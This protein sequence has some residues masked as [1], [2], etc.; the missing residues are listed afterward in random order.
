MQK[1]R[2]SHYWQDREAR[3]EKAK[4]HVA[5]M[6][7]RFPSSI[8]ASIQGTREYW[9]SHRFMCGAGDADVE[10][11]VVALD[12]VSAAFEYTHG[13][14][15]VLNF[16][17]YK[18]PGGAFLAGSRAQEECLC[19][20]S[21]LYHVLSYFQGYY[22]WNKKNLNR[23]LY[24]DRAL[25]SPNVVFVHED[26]KGVVQQRMIDVLTCAAPNFS[27]AS[28]HCSKEENSQ[29]LK[30]RIRFV[31]S[32]MAENNVDTA[33]LGAFGCGVFAQDAAE[34]AEL[35]KEAIPDVFAGR[36]VCIV[37][38]VI[39]ANSENYKK[40]AAVFAEG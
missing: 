6:A 2:N 40:T 11:S 29:A 9:P 31:L 23:G 26:A 27:A 3:A 36:K 14:T 35:F 22:D 28:Y 15:C 17:S 18:E 1:G 4:E 16:A 33:I 24:L 38:A 19:H 30:Q 25:Y 13:R 32:I 37:F 20:E 10:V 34:V 7:S 8:G 5:S 21:A 12:T 39:D